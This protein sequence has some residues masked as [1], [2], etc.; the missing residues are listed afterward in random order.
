M[1]KWEAATEILF[2]PHITKRLSERSS[3]LVVF[4]YK[5]NEVTGLA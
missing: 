1:G 5:P 4:T 3:P 2:F